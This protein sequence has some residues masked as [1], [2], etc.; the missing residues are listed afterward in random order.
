VTP[1]RIVLLLLVLGLA[2]LFVQPLRGWHDARNGLSSAR[3]DL[4]T[5]RAEQA[6]LRKQLAA[7]DT[8]AALVREAREQGYVFPGET[9]FAP[10]SP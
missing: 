6:A 5:A 4:R 1:R 9:P 7:M 2:G 10:A 8:R 3:A